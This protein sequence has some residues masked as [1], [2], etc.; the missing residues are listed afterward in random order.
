MGREATAEAFAYAW[1]NWDRVGGMVNPDGY[2]YRVGQRLGR[3]WMARREPVE[4]VRAEQDLEPVEPRLGSA[5][6]ELSARQRTVVVL[7]HGLGWTHR[8]TAEFLGLTTST[9]QKHVERAVTHLRRSLGV[10]LEA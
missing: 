8:E 3:R 9:V 7:V 4:F 5:L 6:S 10:D 1:E 2:V